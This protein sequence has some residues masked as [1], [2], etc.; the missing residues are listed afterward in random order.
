MSRWK[1]LL[2]HNCRTSS[3]CFS[4]PEQLGYVGPVPHVGLQYLD[5]LGDWDITVQFISAR[6][7]IICCTNWSISR[8][9]FELAEKRSIN[10]YKT[11]AAATA[12]HHEGHS[13]KM[14]VPQNKV[15]QEQIR[16]EGSPGTGDTCWWWSVHLRPLTYRTRCSLSWLSCLEGVENTHVTSIQTV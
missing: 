5:A 2:H 10:E 15:A 16:Q 14:Y 11:E 7:S 3:W 13:M 12:G 6:K 4:R 8:I 9:I 1:F